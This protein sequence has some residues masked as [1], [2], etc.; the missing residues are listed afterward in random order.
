VV[1]VGWVPTDSSG[2]QRTKAH[3]RIAAT[4]TKVRTLDPPCALCVRGT[5]EVGGNAS[6][7]ARADTSCGNKA[8]TFTSAATTIGS[9]AARVWGADGNST[10]NEPA[11]IQQNQPASAFD[12]FTYTADELDILKGFARANGTYY[13]GA[14]TFNSSNQLKNGIVFVDTTTGNPITPNTPASEFA[15]AQIHGGAVADPSGTFTGWIIVNGSLAISGS[16]QMAGMVYVVN[17]LSYTG[18]GAGEIAGLVI[19]QN[20]RDTVATTVDTNAGGNAAILYDCAA[21]RTGGG[22]IP[23]GWF[24]KPG[25]YREVSDG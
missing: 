17:D 13:Q 21:A 15:A 23:Q 25:T 5:L 9:G 12:A 16:F 8:G 20:V 4:L 11:D 14:V 19:S 7:D 6:V 24:V 22:R 2:D 18:T 10:A 1:S 3:Q